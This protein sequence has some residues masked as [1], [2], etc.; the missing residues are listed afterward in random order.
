MK[1]K[2]NIQRGWLFILPLILT[3]FYSRAQDFTEDRNKMSSFFSESKEL[4]LDIRVESFS[5]TPEGKPISVELIKMRRNSPRDFFYRMQGIDMLMNETQMLTIDHEAKAI[6]LKDLTKDE[7]K[8]LSAQASISGN[9]D[10]LTKY[11]DS[12]T[13]NGILGKAKS[14]TMYLKNGMIKK[15]ELYINESTYRPEKLIYYYDKEQT[16]GMESS[17]IHFSSTDPSQLR[18]E[19]YFIEAY[20]KLVDKTYTLTQKFS[21]Y[22]LTLLSHE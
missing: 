6:L 21:S 3:V 12:V 10:S 20:V 13:Y 2:K 19:L 9:L 22:H 15:A 18:K 5:G 8:S 7:K 16:P 4:Y 11:I 1:Q 17:V 14:Y